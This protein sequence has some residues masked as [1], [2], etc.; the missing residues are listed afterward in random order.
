MLRFFPKKTIALFCVILFFSGCNIIKHP[1]KYF[2]QDFNFA[3]AIKHEN[4]AFSP[5]ET[6]T[7]RLESSEITNRKDFSGA[8]TTLLWGLITFTDY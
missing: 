8:K 4:K 5:P 2:T 7:I 6:G 3:G 1:K